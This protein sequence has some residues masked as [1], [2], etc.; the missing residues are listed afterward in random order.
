LFGGN[1]DVTGVKNTKRSETE[2]DVIESDGWLVASHPEDSDF[3]L[4][5]DIGIALEVLGKGVVTGLRTPRGAA[6]RPFSATSTFP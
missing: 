1:G 2:N 4:V 6:R 5:G 3:D